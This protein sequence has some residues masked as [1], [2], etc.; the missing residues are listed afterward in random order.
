MTEVGPVVKDWQEIVQKAHEAQSRIS[1][2]R[3]DDA[4]KDQRDRDHQ[5]FVEY[6]AHL[7][8]IV[9]RLDLARDELNKRLHEQRKTAR[10]WV[11]GIVLTSLGLLSRLIC[12]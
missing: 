6:A 12:S 5:L 8:G 7:S 4:R 11:I 10:R 1:E 3:R 9:V 2:N